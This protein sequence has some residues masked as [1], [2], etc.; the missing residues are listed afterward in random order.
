MHHVITEAKLC[1]ERGDEEQ[2]GIKHRLPFVSLERRRG[3]GNAIW[4]ITFFHSNVVR[5]QG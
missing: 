5:A 2:S 3:H 4:K 1:K